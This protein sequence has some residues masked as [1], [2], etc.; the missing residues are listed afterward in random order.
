MR[1]P[2]N[3][4]SFVQRLFTVTS[5]PMFLVR[6][7]RFGLGLVFLFGFTGN[8][9]S[10]A[11]F[12]RPSL[13]V[14][15]TGSLFFMVAVS[16]TVF[17]LASIFDFVEVGIAQEPIFLSSYDSLC[18]FRWYA[19][20]FAQF[21]SA[22]ILVLITVDRWLRIRFPFKTKQ[23]CTRRKSLIATMAVVIIGTGLYSHMLSAQFFGKR[24]P[25]IAT[26]A[27]GPVDF[28]GSYITFY[29]SRW[30]YVQVLKEYVNENIEKSYFCCR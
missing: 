30:S 15:S 10:I 23:W 16:D 13:R 4:D 24:F 1:V 19:K 20:G 7:Y 14:T 25:G 29:F 5:N 26:E 9:A 11:T 21:C 6:W 18:R 8:F 2:D 12:M 3:N 22:W 28:R 27:C 17:L